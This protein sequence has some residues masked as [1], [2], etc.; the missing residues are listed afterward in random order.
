MRPR[1]ARSGPCTRS[2]STT[3][4]RACGTPRPRSTRWRGR[5][6]TAAA[7][8][9]PAAARAVRAAAG[10]R[11]A[12]AARVRTPIR[13]RPTAAATTPTS[14]PSSASGVA[15][16][17]VPGGKISLARAEEDKP[18]PAGRN[19]GWP[20][21]VQG[22]RTEACHGRSRST[23]PDRRYR[24]DGTGGVRQRLGRQRREPRIDVG[25][26]ELIR[27]AGDRGG[28]LFGRCGKRSGR[29][30]VRGRPGRGPGRGQPDKARY[31]A[32][33]HGHG[34]DAGTSH[35]RRAVRAPGPAGRAALRGRGIDPAGVRG[36]RPELP[37]GHR[38]ADRLPQRDRG[39]DYP[40]VVRVVAPRR[41]ARRGPRRQGPAGAGRSS[42]QRADGAVTGVG[43]PRRYGVGAASALWRRACSQGARCLLG[44]RT[45]L[46]LDQSFRPVRQGFLRS[47]LLKSTNSVTVV[48]PATG[49]VTGSSCPN[50]AWALPP[51]LFTVPG[52]NGP[53]SCQVHPPPRKVV[54][55]NG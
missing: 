32:P 17:G 30:A 29:V 4:A 18:A 36:R 46:P 19:R 20:P 49:N 55:K 6:G 23:E 16:P 21:T 2:R 24:P 33:R 3:S 42:E 50:S 8:A 39:R 26:R 43:V 27:R 5:T 41:A 51:N 52:M 22:G 47:P 28:S 48:D 54:E 12:R 44:A 40:V 9:G 13:G 7:R 11:A 10:R 45:E 37:A 35:D 34:Y 31:D 25:R 14:R 1:R 53:P 15:L 38:A